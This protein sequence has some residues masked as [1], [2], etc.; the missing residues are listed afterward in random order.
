MLIEIDGRRIQKP[1]FCKDTPML[2]YFEALR[3]AHG[4]RGFPKYAEFLKQGAE[5]LAD[6]LIPLTEIPD[7]DFTDLLKCSKSWNERASIQTIYRYV[8][9]NFGSSKCSTAIR[10]S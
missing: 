3:L 2:K 7:D 6:T 5:G 4:C 9:N 8:Y 10:I 1:D